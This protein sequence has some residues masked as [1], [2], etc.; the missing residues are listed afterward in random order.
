MVEFITNNGISLDLDPSGSFEIT[1][2]NPFFASDSIPSPWSTTVGFLPTRKN[3]REFGM[4]MAMMMEPSTT[5]IPADMYVNGF[6]MMSGT[7]IYDSIEDNIINYSFTAKSATDK[8]ESIDISQNNV[9]PSEIKLYSKEFDAIRDGTN[10]AIKA[11]TLII[12]GGAIT[13]TTSIGLRGRYVNHPGMLIS[14]LIPAVQM[15]QFIIDAFGDNIIIDNTILTD[16]RRLYML[17]PYKPEPTDSVI[18]FKDLILKISDTMPKMSKLDMILGLSCIFGAHYYPDG[19][20]YRLLSSEQLL[21]N[22]D[23]IDWGAK[24]S[25]TFSCSS[26]PATG[27]V[28]KYVDD[29]SE[30]CYDGT[31]NDDAGIEKANSYFDVAISRKKPSEGEYIAVEHVPTQDIFSYTLQNVWG[32]DL[33]PTESLLRYNNAID[34]KV[35][36]SEESCEVSLPFKLVRPVPELVYIERGIT[37][38]MLAPIITPPSRGE[39]RGSDVYIGIIDEGQMTDKG[40]VVVPVTGS[41]ESGLNVYED[42]NVGF[43]LSCPYSYNAALISYKM[44]RHQVVNVELNLS[45]KDVAG[46]RMYRRYR[47]AGREWLA[48]K[49]SI[50]VEVTSGRLKCSGEFAAI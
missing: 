11:P 24:V 19:D 41:Q 40:R 18:G 39:E 7:L 43:N 26:D 46:F 30:N 14:M 5:N 6:K 15:Y 10:E 16:L 35:K 29:S 33:F 45:T 31:K 13:S 47:F 8:L 48:K 49:I 44:T 28:M 12:K 1:I 32:Y 3:C 17:C 38:L 4:I 37:R 42:K 25:D 21:H 34:Y 27:F 20:G 50:N 22:S 23:I 2:E 36:G 9:F